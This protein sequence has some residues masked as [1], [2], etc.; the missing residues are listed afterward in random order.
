LDK[1][2]RQRNL[3]FVHLWMTLAFAVALWAFLDRARPHR[4][5]LVAFGV[6][7]GLVGS[8]S[9][10]SGDIANP[11]AGVSHL[12]GA[13]ALLLFVFE[14][15]PRVWPGGEPGDAAVRYTRRI[16]ACV[17]FPVVCLGAAIGIISLRSP[18]HR[19]VDTLRGRI[20]VDRAWA[21]LYERAGREL[22]AGERVL[23]LPEVNAVDAVFRARSVSPFVTMMP[24]WLDARA[25]SDLI[26]RFEK[27]PPDVV[28]VFRRPNWE[29]GVAPFGQGF[30]LRVADWV[31]R[32][33]RVVYE[34][35]GG[36]VR[37]RIPAS[38]ASPP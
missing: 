11:Y 26:R 7:A 4:E 36:V 30:G 12:P 9:A 10:F 25:E 3:G 6:F 23:A 2:L 32:N 31:E 22:R 17:L 29:Y 28:V 19:P 14:F 34:A 21:D 20:W 5:A 33:S 37:R 35:A 24:G 16:W 13:L 18:G 15:L 38:G 27:E 8:R 1:S